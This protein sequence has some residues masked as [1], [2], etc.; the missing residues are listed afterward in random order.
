MEGTRGWGIGEQVLL[1]GTNFQQVVNKPQRS[2]AQ[3]SEY[4]E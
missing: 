4:R 3:Y 2:N 1:K